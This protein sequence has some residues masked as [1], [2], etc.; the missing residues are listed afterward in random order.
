MKWWPVSAVPLGDQYEPVKYVV[1]YLPRRPALFI[2][3][4]PACGEEM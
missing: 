2:L 1:V 3:K 4:R